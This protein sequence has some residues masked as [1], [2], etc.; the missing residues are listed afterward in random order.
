MVSEYRSEISGIVGLGGDIMSLEMLVGLVLFNII[1]LKEV[2]TQV[3]DNAL[4][5]ERERERDERSRLGK[6]TSP[7]KC[8]ELTGFLVSTTSYTVVAS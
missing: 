7:I 3:R 4:K 6:V 1:M 8:E 5:D 2:G